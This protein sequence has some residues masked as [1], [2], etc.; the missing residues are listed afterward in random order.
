MA[1]IG[2]LSRADLIRA[3]VLGVPGVVDLSG[4]AFGEVAT[5]LPGRTVRGVRERDDGVHVHVVLATG[6]QIPAVAGAVHVAVGALTGGPVHVHVEDLAP[7]IAAAPISAPVSTPTIVG[8][9][10]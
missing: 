8:E 5:Y 4:G 10:P 1:D 7:A 9:Q 2:A 6:A 3:A